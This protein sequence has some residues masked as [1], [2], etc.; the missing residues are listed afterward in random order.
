MGEAR[1]GNRHYTD[2]DD[3]HALDLL[4]HI[5]GAK[6]IATYPNAR[7]PLPTTGPCSRCGAPTIRYGPA[8][9]P[10]ATSAEIT[11][12]RLREPET[13]TGGQA[14][15]ALEARPRWPGPGGGA[16]A[17]C[18]PAGPRQMPAAS[19]AALLTTVKSVSNGR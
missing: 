19:P 3:T 11:P 8:E 7:A 12:A 1:P 2:A 6:V 9:A 17:A 13:R 10:S 18:S 15:R 14:V 5:L 16:P 4:R